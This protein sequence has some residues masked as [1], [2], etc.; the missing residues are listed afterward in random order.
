YARF[1]SIPSFGK[2][3]IRR[4]PTNVSSMKQQVARHFEDMLQCA[5]PAFEGLFPDK[6]DDVIRI[7]LFRMA[8]W[9]AL[10]KM[11]LHSDETL[12]LLEKSLRR[13]GAQ[14]RKFSKFTCSAFRTFE[15]PGEIAARHRNQNHTSESQPS[16]K[17][18]GPRPKSFNLFTYKLHALGDYMQSI[19][20]FGTTDSYTTQIVSTLFKNTRPFMTHLWCRENWHIVRSRNSTR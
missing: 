17:A 10:A 2:S 11:R 4:F 16:M 5:I 15:L 8:E 18:A 1:R 7:L 20:V 19:K 14:L 12:I 13:L 9:H 3:S 6:H